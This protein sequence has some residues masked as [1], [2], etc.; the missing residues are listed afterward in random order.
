MLSWANNIEN[1]RVL[2]HLL[3]RTP[4]KGL[5][6]V[7]TLGRKSHPSMHYQLAWIYGKGVA[8]MVQA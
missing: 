7:T 6:F 8:A 2:Q 3:M 1:R 5:Y 4:D